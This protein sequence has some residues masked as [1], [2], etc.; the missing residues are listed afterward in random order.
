MYKSIMSHNLMYNQSKDK[1]KPNPIFAVS[2]L[3]FST[4]IVFDC[5]VCR[6]LPSKWSCARNPKCYNAR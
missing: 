2:L 6:I 4:L 1:A 5:S 3:V